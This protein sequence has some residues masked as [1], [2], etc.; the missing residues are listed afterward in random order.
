MIIPST[1]PRQHSNM[2]QGLLVKDKTSVGGYLPFL[3][4][5]NSPSHLVSK[6]SKQVEYW[7]NTKAAFPSQFFT[8]RKQFYNCGKVQLQFA[9]VSFEGCANNV[10]LVLYY[11]I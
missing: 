4:L 1:G 7:A 2:F 10:N 8:K 5:Q 9:G 6:V 11:N 3:Y